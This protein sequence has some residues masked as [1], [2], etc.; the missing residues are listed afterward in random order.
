MLIEKTQR[1]TL[2]KFVTLKSLVMQY[3]DESVLRTFCEELIAE[4]DPAHVGTWAYNAAK[5]LRFLDSGNPSFSV[6][7]VSGNTKLPFL[8]FSSLPLATCPGMGECQNF[9]YSIRSWRYPA[10]FF[11]QLQN[12]VLM[13]TPEGRD[14][15]FNEMSKILSSRKFKKQTSIDFRLYVDGDFDSV[16][17]M[18]FWFLKV[19]GSF[20]KVRAYGYSK[21][22]DVFRSYVDSIGTLPDNYVLNLSSG[23]KY[24]DDVMLQEYMQSLSVTREKFIAIPIEG[25]FSAAKGDYMTRRYRTAVRNATK[26]N[27]IEKVFVCPGRCGSCTGAGHACGIPNLNIPFAIGIH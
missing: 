11:K 19:L 26:S 13:M 10:A 4:G 3:T 8:S 9:C 14:S 5:F 16:E 17:T 27:G 25:K 24:D 2:M 20:P 18:Q 23:S 7:S 15:I 21:S 6:F 12:A 1:D 22:F